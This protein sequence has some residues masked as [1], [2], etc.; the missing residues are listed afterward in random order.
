MA[1]RKKSKKA[2]V[3][4]RRRMSGIGSGLGHEAM[5]AVGL[6][7][8]NIGGVI[9]QRQLT[10]VNPKIVSGAQIIVGYLIKK[11]AKSPLMSGVGWGMMSAGSVGLVHEVGIIHGV[12][13]FVSGL[14][15]GG[16][17]YEVDMP[18][19]GLT[20]SSVMSGLNNSSTVTHGAN[21]DVVRG[22]M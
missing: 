22:M 12:E 10:S 14:Y 11:H 3:R 8:A 6:V 20:N 7:A 9:M 5:E 16:S 18:M 17:S 13:D 21:G 19:R 4:R 1:K 15:G 2:P